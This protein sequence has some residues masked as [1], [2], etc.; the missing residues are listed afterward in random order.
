MSR[1]TYFRGGTPIDQSVTAACLDRI[2]DWLD[3]AD[4]QVRTAI[5]PEVPALTLP[6]E[7][8]IAWC[9]AALL[10]ADSVDYP[11]E[12]LRQMSNGIKIGLKD[13]G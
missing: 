9:W 1:E 8:P 5:Y 12:L 6:H 7:L 3:L 11:T 10:I 2:A 13:S 4:N